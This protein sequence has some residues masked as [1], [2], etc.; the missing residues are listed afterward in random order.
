MQIAD[1]SDLAIGDSVSFNSNIAQIIGITPTSI[2][3]NDDIAITLGASLNILY[4]QKGNQTMDW[5]WKFPDRSDNQFVLMSDDD[6]PQSIGLFIKGI[7]NHPTWAKG[8]AIVRQK[9][10]KNILYQAHP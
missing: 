2:T 5:A 1:T 6:K 3:I 10:V 9:R 7:K 4:S 8:F